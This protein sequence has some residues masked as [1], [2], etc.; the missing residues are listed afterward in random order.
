M[1]SIK[2]HECEGTYLFI[3]TR[4]PLKTQTGFYHIFLPGVSVE[5]YYFTPHRFNGL[6]G[7]SSSLAQSITITLDDVSS[8]MRKKQQFQWEFSKLSVTCI[9]DYTCMYLHNVVFYRSSGEL[10]NSC[11]IFI[12]LRSIN[13][14]WTSNLAASYLSTIQCQF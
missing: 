7:V 5:P 3:L 2:E 13:Y 10:K 14:V 4:L 9:G 8:T 11:F 6:E 1:T 12:T